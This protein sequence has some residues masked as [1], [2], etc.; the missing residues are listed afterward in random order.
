MRLRRGLVDGLDSTGLRQSDSI[1]KGGMTSDIRSRVKYKV[2]R[3]LDT[4][5]NFI[6][7]VCPE[8]IVKLR[9]TYIYQK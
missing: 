8:H 4:Y 7:F 1:Q 3:V 2:I 5:R 9:G 6:H